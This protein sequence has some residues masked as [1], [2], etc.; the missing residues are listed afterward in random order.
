MRSFFDTV[1]GSFADLISSS[2]ADPVPIIYRERQDGAT[3]ELLGIIRT[4]DTKEVFQEEQIQKVSK[5]ELVFRRDEESFWPGITSTKL[6]GQFEFY[7]STWE[8]M[9]LET[10][11]INA[12]SRTFVT[13]TV[14]RTGILSIGYPGRVREATT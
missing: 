11:A 9:V 7:G 10:E 13:L 6:R 5:V 8:Q 2:F 12:E 1:Y 4:V 14:R 3:R